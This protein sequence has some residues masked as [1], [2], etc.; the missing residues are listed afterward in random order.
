[1]LTS[2]STLPDL[3]NSALITSSGTSDWGNSFEV[4]GRIKNQGG[5]TTTAPFQIVIYASP[6]RGIMKYSLPIG[7]VTVPAGL[8]PARRCRTTRL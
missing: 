7:E 8:A 2:Q 4:E 6:I 3:V 1:M 5:S